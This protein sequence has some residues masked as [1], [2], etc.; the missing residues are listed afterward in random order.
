M[1]VP[2]GLRR[3]A[4]AVG[5]LALAV[6]VVRSA[7]VQA[8]AERDPQTA[9]AIWSGHPSAAIGLASVE[10]AKA[11][12]AGKPIDDNAFETL[13]LA[14]TK[15]P[16]EPQPFIVRGIRLQL[17]GRGDDAER[18]FAAA[19]WRN[20]RSIPARYFLAN[21]RLSRGNVDGL[22]EVAA[23]ARLSPEGLVTSTPY[24]AA[25]ARQKQAL[26][27]MRALFAS[28]P[29]IRSAV[30]SNLA[31]DPGNLSLVLELG[32]TG[33]VAN[34]PW[35]AAMIR[36]LV[37]HRQYAP[38]RSLWEKSSGIDRSATQS[39]LFD[40][41]FSDSA[42]MPPFNWEL[43]SSTLGLAE[44]RSGRLQAIYYGQDNG[45]LARQLLVLGPGRY[46]FEAPAKGAVESGEG[47]AL[48]WTV[49][50][51][52]SKG[53]EALASAPASAGGLTFVVPASCPAQWLE[54]AGR[55]SDTGREIEMTI[56]PVS[57]SR[58]GGE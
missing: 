57:L 47:T 40:A 34:A 39:L 29:A 1:R 3:S 24:L 32:G 51:A 55:S 46:R 56:G 19:S 53:N 44:R 43:T 31:Q 52:D 50:C 7:A 42:S 33:D 11:A 23:L 2:P 28:N 12:G 30:L 37:E 17:E 27:P 38:A 58:A 4:A 49:R 18:A 20:P 5:A 48:L 26:K 16:L 41:N 9:E 14:A 25:F 13:S 36:T 54:L 6:V 10:I 8:F 22:R 35:L 21:T 45:P 15:A